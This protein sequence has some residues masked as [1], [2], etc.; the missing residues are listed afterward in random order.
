MAE[1][2]PHSGLSLLEAYRVAHDAGM[3]L[4]SD[5]IDVKV[6]PTI[7]PGWREIPLR[8]KIAAPDRGTIVYSARVAA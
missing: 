1:I 7:P 5:G 3:Y 4:I 2:I 6:A 8:V